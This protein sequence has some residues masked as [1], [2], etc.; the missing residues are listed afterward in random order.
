MRKIIPFGIIC[1]AILFCVATFFNENTFV[2]TACSLVLVFFIAKVT[3]MANAIKSALSAVLF[4][5]LAGITEILAAFIIIHFQQGTFVSFTVFSVLRFQGLIMKNLLFFLF[6]NIIKRIREKAIQRLPLNLWCLLMLFP[7]ISIVIL[8][9]M[10]MLLLDN[11]G[12]YET[13]TVFS[14][15]GLLLL[16]F[17]IYFLVENI[18]RGIETQKRLKIAEIMLDSQRQRMA[19]FEESRSKLRQI[20]HDT[21]HHAICIQSLANTR[22]YDELDAYIQ[23]FLSDIPE[24]KVY[25]D[26][27]NPALDAILSFKRDAAK[28]NNIVCDWNIII[29]AELPLLDMELSLLM[30]N[31]LDNAI[32]ACCHVETERRIAL[33]MKTN[34]GCL[35]IEIENTLGI[36]PMQNGDFYISGKKDPERHG[37]GLDSMKD[38]VNRMN[39]NMSLEYDDEVFRVRIL[40]PLGK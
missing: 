10:I 35:L 17:L 5:F 36:P 11:P 7:C 2:I 38:C 19:D 8:I 26:T 6:T 20:T 33:R 24:A 39:G 3:Y 23:R 4:I 27:G 12:S 13:L 9:D 22:Q 40:L 29:P 31:A 32:E 15:I 34:A 30:G 1:G 25:Y 14:V 37:L 28:V 18:L 21:K 16:N